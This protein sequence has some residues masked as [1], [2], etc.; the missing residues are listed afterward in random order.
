MDRR[1]SRVYGSDISKGM[2]E[3]ATTMHARRDGKHLFRPQSGEETPLHSVKI[4]SFYNDM[5]AAES[6]ER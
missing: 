1:E 4:S 2:V 5:R 6:S 3:K